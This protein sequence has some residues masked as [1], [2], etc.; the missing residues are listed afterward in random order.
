MKI[1]GN[2]KVRRKSEIE[3]RSKGRAIG[4]RGFEETQPLAIFNDKW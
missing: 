2:C 1:Y 4:C 3:I